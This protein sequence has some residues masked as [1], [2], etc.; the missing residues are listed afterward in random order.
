MANPD[1]CRESGYNGK[2][3]SLGGVVGREGAG[4]RIVTGSFVGSATVPSAILPNNPARKWALIELAPDETDMGYIGFGSRADGTRFHI[5]AGGSILINDNLPWSGVV[6]VSGS[7]NV[8]FF[9]C[10]ASVQ[11]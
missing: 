9:Y 11:E 2:L 6:Y 3:T 7:G 10:E 4:L 5:K 8:E 1:T